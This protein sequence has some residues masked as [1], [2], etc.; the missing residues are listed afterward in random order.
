MVIR[1]ELAAPSAIPF[2]GMRVNI[3]KK[4][5]P[6]NWTFW[7][8]SKSFPSVPSH[9][10]L[11]PSSIVMI[12]YLLTNC[13]VVDLFCSSTYS[14]AFT[15]EFGTVIDFAF[16][17]V[18]FWWC[19]VKSDEYVFTG[20]YP[21]ASIA[22]R[23]VS[24]SSSVPFET[25]ANPHRHPTYFKTTKFRIFLRRWKFQHPNEGF[26]ECRR[27]RYDHE[28]LESVG[29][30]V[31]TTVDDVHHW[32]GRAVLSPPGSCKWDFKVVS[33]GTSYSDRHQG[34][35]SHPIYLC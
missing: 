3:L 18:E 5:S 13:W 27:T 16:F 15:F 32:V 8:F 4:S 33:N 29:A 21:A 6:T 11:I 34:L 17:I 35:R 1:I 22:A 9:F 24:F 28:F 10:I 14:S 30:S 19:A 20:T 23:V 12:G 2:Q 7:T 25:R 26:F 31:R